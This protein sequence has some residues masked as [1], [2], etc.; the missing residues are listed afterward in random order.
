MRDLYD[1]L[2]LYPNMKPRV[3]S[4][5]IGIAW[6]SSPYGNS[7]YNP[8][9]TV[10]QFTLH[11]H[12]LWKANGK[13][14]VVWVLLPCHSFEAQLAGFH[15]CKYSHIPNFIEVKYKYKKQLTTSCISAHRWHWTFY[16]WTLFCM[17]TNNYPSARP[18]ENSLLVSR[19][20]CLRA[21]GKDTQILLKYG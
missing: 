11:R 9:S 3:I 1:Q 7:P 4:L 14:L 21:T 18:V 10:Q 19:N 6:A 12:R 2:Q 16:I 15:Y 13:R 20:E 5:Q 8:S 17:A